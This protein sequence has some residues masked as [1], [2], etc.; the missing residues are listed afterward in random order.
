MKNPNSQHVKHLLEK[1]YE[2]FPWISSSHCQSSP[3]NPQKITSVLKNKQTKENKLSSQE[4]KQSLDEWNSGNLVRIRFSFLYA[5]DGQIS[6]K[7]LLG[8]L[9][10]HQ[11][12]KKSN[13]D[14]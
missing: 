14:F 2:I 11:F 7:E 3:T 6:L 5:D 8:T 12:F 9:S 4:S 1:D 10:Q 13:N